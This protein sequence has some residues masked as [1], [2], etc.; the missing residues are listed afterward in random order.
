MTNLNNNNLNL[1]LDDKKG[2]I[3]LILTVN[4][5]INGNDKVKNNILLIRDLLNPFKPHQKINHFIFYKLE[6]PQKK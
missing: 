3:N 4:Y 1:I 5:S 6:R 2:N